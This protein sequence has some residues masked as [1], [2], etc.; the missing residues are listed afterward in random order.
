M[1]DEY[2][3][4][5]SSFTSLFYIPCWSTIDDEIVRCVCGIIVLLNGAHS[6]LELVELVVFEIVLETDASICQI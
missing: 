4:A 1:K 2:L 3:R 5:F 6:F